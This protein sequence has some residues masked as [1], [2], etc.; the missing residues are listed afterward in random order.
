M[1][2]SGLDLFLL[3]NDWCCKKHIHYWLVRTLLNIDVIYNPFTV[4]VV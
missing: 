3:N 1:K 2:T 4:L